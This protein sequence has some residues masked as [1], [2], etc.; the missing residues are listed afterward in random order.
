MVEMSTRSQKSPFL[1]LWMVAFWTLFWLIITV[2]YVLDIDFF[3]M[4]V[5]VATGNFEIELLINLTR[6]SKS[7]HQTL[8]VPSKENGKYR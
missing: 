8:L 4:H 5:F 3:T 1:E 7:R 6:I 2:F